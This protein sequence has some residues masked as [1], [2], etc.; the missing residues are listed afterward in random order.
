MAESPT[1]S[2]TTFTATTNTAAAGEHKPVI[3]GEGG[4]PTNSSYVSN[5][6]FFPSHQL[7]FSEGRRSIATREVERIGN[8]SFPRD[9]SH[10]LPAISLNSVRHFTHLHQLD[11]ARYPT[12][13]YSTSTSASTPSYIPSNGM[14]MDRRS[15]L[16]ASVPVLP[17]LHQPFAS[18]DTKVH[19]LP[20]QDLSAANGSAEQQWNNN[21]S[22]F[23]F[24]SYAKQ[25]KGFDEKAIDPTFFTDPSMVKPSGPSTTAP[26]GY[27]GQGS[28]YDR[29]VMSQHPG[30]FPTPQD[31]SMIT[32]GRFANGA[33][34]SMSAANGNGTKQSPNQSRPPPVPAPQTMMTT[35]SSKTVSS[36][37]K[38][39]KCNVCQKRFTR[40]SSLQTHMYSHTGEKRERSMIFPIRTLEIL[41]Q[42]S[43][44]II[45]ETLNV[46]LN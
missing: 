42:K 35:F 5:D 45:I 38:R 14:H 26:I 21:N 37:P 4:Y 7:L 33:M 44:Y 22:P 13:P 27:Y 19:N 24:G 31:Y 9:R 25:A 36:T 39:Y 11:S 3:N 17:I 23:P 29:N 10:S 18:H 46:D 6:R 41:N 28:I 2:P 12:A 40:P 16:G 15:S 20:H 8:N 34:N 32:A 43:Y 1:H 30:G